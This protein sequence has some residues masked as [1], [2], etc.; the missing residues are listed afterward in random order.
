LIAAPPPNAIKSVAFV[1]AAGIAD[2][3]LTAAG[4]R[5][6]QVTEGVQLAGA[7]HKSQIVMKE[8]EFKQPYNLTSDAPA[9]KVIVAIRL[10]P[11]ATT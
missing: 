7:R 1:A 6:G 11:G 3:Q 9:G 5:V 2:A 8:A 10:E 4:V